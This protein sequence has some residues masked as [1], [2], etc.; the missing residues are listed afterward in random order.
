MNWSRC[1]LLLV[2]LVLLQLLLLLLVMMVVLIACM[3]R[4]CHGLC[5]WCSV[6]CVMV[7][8]VTLLGS[9]TDLLLGHTVGSMMYL[10]VHLRMS[11][12]TL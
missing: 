9:L 1:V 6:L 2:N 4:V 8:S 10:R 12:M 11:G 7:C 3:A 5:R